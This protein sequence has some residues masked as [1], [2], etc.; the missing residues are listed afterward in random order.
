[1]RNL[2]I[3]PARSGSKGIKDKNIRSI[4]GKPLI[5]YTIEAALKSDVFDTI[6]VSTDSDVY[7]EISKQCGAEG[8][9]LRSRRTSC[10]T[11]SSWDVV[12]EVLLRYM[13]IGKDFDT[14]MLLQPTSPLRTEDHIIGAYKELK[15]KMANTIVSVCEADHSPEQYNVLP[16]D[17]SLNGFINNENSRKRRQDMRVY[18]RLNGAIYLSKTEFFLE[19]KDIYAQKAYAYIMSRVDSIDIDDELDLMI[20]EMLIQKKKRKI[21]T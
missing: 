17:C 12:E 20:A 8:P 13:D 1:M 6:M 11:S 2:A 3:I 7:A 5:G 9:F 14:F 19:E 4:C 18:Y 16:D 10:D 15:E 21:S